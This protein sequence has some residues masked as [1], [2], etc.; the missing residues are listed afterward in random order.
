MKTFGT[1][2]QNDYTVEDLYVSSPISWQLVSGSTGI[3]LSGYDDELDGAVMVQRASLTTGESAINVD[4]LTYEHILHKSVRHLFYTNGYFFDGIR[5]LTSSMVPLANDCYVVSVGLNFYGDRIKPGS[6]E[7]S[8]ELAN[9]YV[10]DDGHGNLYVSQSGT[11]SYVGNIFYNRGV[12]VITQATG[13]GVTA[14]NLSGLKLVS[15]SSVYVDYNS[16]VKLHRH[17]INVKL[18]PTDFN[19]SPFNP[20]ITNQY[21]STGSFSSSMMELNIQSSSTNAGMWDIYS[22]MN[23]GII[24]PY[25]TTIG[26]YNEQYELL[27]VAKF[28]QPIQRTFSANQIFI[29]RFDA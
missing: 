2:D 4:T 24:P 6:F 10:L 23:D 29:V 3:Q 8:T 19:M 14:I 11:G 22:L 15:G 17:E 26:L 27:A 20:S 18:S 9:K 1:I 28:N 21:A 7:L 12:A 13:S 25:V 5:L 16:D